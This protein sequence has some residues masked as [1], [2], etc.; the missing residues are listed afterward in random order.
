MLLAG[1]DGRFPPDF[2]FQLTAREKDQVVAS[3]DHLW[4]VKFSKALRTCCRRLPAPWA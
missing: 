3:C 4:N 1:A 2:M